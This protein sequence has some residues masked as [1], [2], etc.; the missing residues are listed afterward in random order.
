MLEQLRPART[1]NTGQLQPFLI[2]I[3]FSHRVFVSHVE[4]LQAPPALLGSAALEISQPEIKP[5]A[6]VSL[7]SN[8]E[9]SVAD[10]K[11][12]TINPL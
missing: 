12:E 8:R 10:K 7:C 1:V 3:F 11:E 4:P 9:T 2:F 6:H 5:R